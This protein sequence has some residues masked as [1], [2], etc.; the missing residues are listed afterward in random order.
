[1]SNTNTG[2]AITYITYHMYK[3]LKC[4]KFLKKTSK[5]IFVRQ[6]TKIG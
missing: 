6:R 3:M 1:M 2:H 5:N 4:K